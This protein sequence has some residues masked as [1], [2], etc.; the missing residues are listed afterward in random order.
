MTPKKKISSLF[1]IQTFEFIELIS[2]GISL[3]QIYLLEL[4]EKNADL[5][6]LLKDN[7]QGLGSLQ[8][9]VRRGYIIDGAISEAGQ[10]LLNYIRE[11][12]GPTVRL[13]KRASMSEDEFETF[14]QAYP[15]TDTIVINDRIVMKGTRA[16]RK[17]D[18][19]DLRVKLSKILLEG[20]YSLEDI[21]R[22]LRF[23][24]KQKVDESLK[25]KENKLS[26]MQNI[27]SYI[28][29]RTFEAY[30][31]ISKLKDSGSTPSPKTFITD[32]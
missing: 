8:A 21:I 12:A 22:A 30:I 4:A 13:K 1:N 31:E 9:L 10:K 19:Q 2:S 29:Q 20:K 18:K 14:W 5:Q 11:A 3:D 15:A 16:L 7:L 32:I 23:E 17:G 27:S 24:V 26:F 28:N 6:E 25:K